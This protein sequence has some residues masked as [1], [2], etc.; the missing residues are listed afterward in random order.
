MSQPHN[1]GWVDPDLHGVS[2]LCTL[3]GHC[4]CA[5]APLHLDPT[6]HFANSS[7][8]NGFPADQQPTVASW[9]DSNWGQLGSSVQIPFPHSSQHNASV[10]SNPAHPLKMRILGTEHGF[11]HGASNVSAAIPYSPVQTHASPANTGCASTEEGS[12][13][14]GCPAEQHITQ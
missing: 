13:Y 5:C 12:I 10:G 3:C 8:I 6:R 9:Y 1:Y 2:G 11:M 7:I 14:Y 4:P